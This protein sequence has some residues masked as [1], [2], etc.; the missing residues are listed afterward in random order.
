MDSAPPTVRSTESYI[1]VSPGTYAGAIESTVVGAST[2]GMVVIAADRAELS[3]KYR[4]GARV[5]QELNYNNVILDWNIQGFSIR[6]LDDHQKRHVDSYEKYI[7]DLERVVSHA[8]ALYGNDAIYI[9]AHS[10]G[11]HIALRT[12]A[13]RPEL[14]RAAILF[15][16]MID[17]ACNRLQFWLYELLSIVMVSCGLGRVYVAGERGYS[18]LDRDF[19]RNILTHDPANF[20]HKHRIIAINPDLAPGG[21]TWAWMHA[22]L[23]SIRQLQTE[24]TAG[25]G[26]DPGTDRVGGRRSRREQRG[27]SGFENISAE[28]R[29]GLYSRFVS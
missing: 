17:I 12:M 15:A 21:P 29:T 25:A 6:K 5:L 16:P 3:E 28:R 4:E 8:V 7:S 27:A 9:L 22:T 19:S 1:L 23:R 13:R 2:L 26:N 24:A 10:M 14:I 18:N 11:G 20:A